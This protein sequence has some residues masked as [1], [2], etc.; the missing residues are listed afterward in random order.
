MHF[1]ENK[2]CLLLTSVLW[3]LGGAGMCYVVE[4]P[5]VHVEMDKAGMHRTLNYRLRFDIPLVGKDCEYALL[6]DFPASVYISTDELDDLQRLKRLNAIYPKFV[7]I[8]VATERAQPFSVLLLGTPKITE[9]LA[10]P[11]HFRY[12]APSDKRC[13]RWPQWPYPYPSSILTARWLIVRSSRTSWL[14]GPI[15]IT[16]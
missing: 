15:S 13:D 4:P 12:H 6:Q 2:K 14:S 11:L 10:L 8:E 1:K 5:I 16:A 3:L 9:S 7:N